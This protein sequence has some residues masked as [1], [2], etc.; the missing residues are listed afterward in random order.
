MRDSELVSY[1]LARGPD[2]FG[3]IVE[4][5]KVALFGVAFARIGDFHDAED[6]TQEAFLQAYLR[7]ESLR[8][9]ERLGPWL[10]S[11]VANLCANQIK[12]RVKGRE[13]GESLLRSMPTPQMRHEQH[14]SRR[15]VAEAMR[16]LGK[17]HRETAAMFYL[18]G[19]S[20]REIARMQD[21]QVGTVK[22]RLHAARQQLH[23]EMI[24]M[25]SDTL[26]ENAPGEDFSRRVYELLSRY[27]A[28]TR[29]PPRDENRNAMA[30][31]ETIGPAGFDGFRQALNSPHWPTRT[32]A[33]KTLRNFPP[34]R[35][36]QTETLLR[37]ALND[38]N[39]RVR[40]QCA[41]A[42]FGLGTTP[43]KR[44]ELI[45]LLTPLLLDD[46][47]RVRR[48]VAGSLLRNSKWWPVI[49]VAPVAE[50]LLWAETPKTRALMEKLLRELVSSDNN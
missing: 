46:S 23:E 19:Y 43:K 22:S 48:I 24:E 16:Q 10:R 13:V 17:L 18:G 15:K 37:Q 44:K 31:L 35:A 11:I 20:Q 26:K 7:L 34:L 14:E 32:Y 30:E 41:S 29:R 5:Y 38:R 47:H 42:L 8:D 6:L 3:A 49:P 1:A 33:I 12:R 36:E 39:R 45:Q 27:P 4:R 9:R 40:R 50:A 25:V 28:K 21:V 2:G